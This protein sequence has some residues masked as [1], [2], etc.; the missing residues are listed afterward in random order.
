MRKDLAIRADS[1]DLLLFDVC[2]NLQLSPT[3]HQKAEARYHA[4]ANVISSVSSPFRFLNSSLYSQGSMRLRTTVKP[5]E[6]PHDLDLVCEFHVSH[7]DVDPM[8]LLDAMF[9]L[10]NEHG[11][12]GGMVTKKNRCVRIEYRDEFWLDILPA[13]RDGQNGGTCIQVPDRD[14]RHWKPSNPIAYAGWFQNASRRIVVKFSD[15][16]REL[17]IAEASIE[18]LPTQQATEEKTVCSWLFNS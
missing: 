1:L 5:I 13:C 6:N 9:N 8:A 12:Y 11:V 7:N 18:P 16:R 2:D 15:S 4:I 14:L 17:L 3:R 10:F